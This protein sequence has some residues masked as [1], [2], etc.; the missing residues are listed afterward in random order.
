MQIRKKI[1]IQGGCFLLGT[2]LY[3]FYGVWKLKNRS[4]T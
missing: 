1:E 3:F 2:F 4:E